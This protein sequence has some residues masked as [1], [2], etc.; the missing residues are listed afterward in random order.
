[1]ARLTTTRK[2]Q[3]KSTGPSTVFGS[4]RAA[5]LASTPT[6]SKPVVEYNPGPSERDGPMTLGPCSNA[7]VFE[8]GAYGALE[9]EAILIVLALL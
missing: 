4:F 5:T 3:L 2:L 9:D 7:C 8:G 6:M 1:M